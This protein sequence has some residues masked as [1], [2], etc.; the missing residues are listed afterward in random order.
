ML[1]IAPSN[2]IDTHISRNT[3]CNDTSKLN[4]HT[5]PYIN[6]P[7]D[8]SELCGHTLHISMPCYLIEFYEH[9]TYTQR[10]THTCTH[11]HTH[12]HAHRNTHT[13]TCTQ[14][15]THN[16]S[17]YHATIRTRCGKSRT[18]QIRKYPVTT[19]YYMNIKMFNIHLISFE[20]SFFMTSVVLLRG[21]PALYRK[22]GPKL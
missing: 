14:R 5:H 21:M 22:H 16:T 9:R 20:S 4:G 1:F 2:F 17:I 15:H 11:I 19:R 10:H 12:T 18:M 8:T 6:T 7:C 13:H 3:P